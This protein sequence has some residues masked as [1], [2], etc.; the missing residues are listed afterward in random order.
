[1][2]LKPLAVIGQYAI[3]HRAIRRLEEGGPNKSVLLELVRRANAREQILDISVADD[4]LVQ[5]TELPRFA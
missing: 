2:H 5:A 4:G 1:M 3:T